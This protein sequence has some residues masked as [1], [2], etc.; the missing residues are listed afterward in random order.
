MDWSYK[1]RLQNKNTREENSLGYK[2]SHLGDYYFSFF[3]HLLDTE[4]PAASYQTEYFL[5]HQ[6]TIT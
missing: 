6:S 2:I 4:H 1:T 3:Q 5:D